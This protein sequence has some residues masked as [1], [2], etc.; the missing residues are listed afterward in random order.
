M[1]KKNVALLG[2]GAMLSLALAGSLGA[3]KIASAEPITQDNEEQSGKMNVTYHADDAWSVTIPEAIEIGG[4]E[5]TVSVADGMK[6]E[7]GKSL[8][9]T[10]S[11]K[12]SWKVQSASDVSGENGYEY[13]LKK[14]GTRVTSEVLSV[15][16]GTSG[17][18]TASLTAELT[19]TAK[20]DAEK[21][22]TGDGDYTDELTFTVTVE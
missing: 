8:K 4:S 5:V 18:Q 15:G 6:I 16:A 14:D 19:E 17:E 20:T 7:K 21:Y 22:S 2:A 10:V 13:E 1:K 3:A 12:N 11:S 9:I